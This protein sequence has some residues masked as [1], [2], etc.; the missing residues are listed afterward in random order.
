M[1]AEE[2]VAAANGLKA[3]LAWGRPAFGKNVATQISA[4]YGCGRSDNPGLP[5]ASKAA[6]GSRAYNG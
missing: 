2:R 3:V 1:N 5:A 6:D 4:V